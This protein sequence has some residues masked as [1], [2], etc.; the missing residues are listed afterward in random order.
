MHY[1]SICLCSQASHSATTVARR[2]WLNP[3][4]AS[5]SSLGGL[6][7]RCHFI[8]PSSQLQAPSQE[9]KNGIHNLDRADSILQGLSSEVDKELR[10]LLTIKQEEAKDVFIDDL[11][12]TLDAH[13]TTNRAAI[14][15]K[16][17]QRANE[18]SLDFKRPVIGPKI[19]A[20]DAPAKG[21][22]TLP[23]KQRAGVTPKPRG[24]SKTFDNTNDGGTDP[25]GDDF[26]AATQKTAVSE[27]QQ[28]EK[29]GRDGMRSTNWP[30]DSIQN[31]SRRGRRYSIGRNEILEYDAMYIAPRG[32]YR[33]VND[34][35]SC[36]WLQTLAT[37]NTKKRTANASRR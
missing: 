8:N 36:P 20:V 3:K 23:R 12:A 1:R 7:S 24:I 33:Y 35:P 37:S 15:R 11:F 4:S 6:F 5:S 10:E 16:L 30:A 32:H 29:P 19:N 21:G 26:R 17:N 25:H 14:V 27:N 13:R 9:T 18:G 2:R 31:E 28:V 22:L 34:N